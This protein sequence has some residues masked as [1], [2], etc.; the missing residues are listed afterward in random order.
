MVG[1]DNVLVVDV[2]D[3]VTEAVGQ[4]SVAVV[5]RVLAK[6]VLIVEQGL[7]VHPQVLILPIVVI[8][9]PVTV[10]IGNV[11][12]QWLVPMCPLLV[13]LVQEVHPELVAVLI[14]VILRKIVLNCLI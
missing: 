8:I 9:T 6:R 5:V 10:T 11:V 7:F 1:H 4:L 3:G 13:V 2:C 14:V 12:V